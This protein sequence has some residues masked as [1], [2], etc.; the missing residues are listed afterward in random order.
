MAVEQISFVIGLVPVVRP[1]RSNP[2]SQ[3]WDRFDFAHGR[4]WGTRLKRRRFFGFTLTME[5]V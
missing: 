4:L 2:R 1:P 5:Q 3:N